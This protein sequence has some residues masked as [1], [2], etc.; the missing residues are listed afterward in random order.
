MSRPTAP[1]AGGRAA[2][3]DHA[4]PAVPSVIVLAGGR[5]A[6]LGG[7]KAERTVD[8][9]RLLDRVLAAAHELSDDVLLMSGA[10][11]LG[12]VGVRVLPDWPDVGGPLGGL[13]AGLTAARH[14][15]CLLLP[16]DLPQPSV[17]VARALLAARESGSR[18]VVVRDASGWQPFHGLYA[19][20]LLPELRAAVQRG[21]RSLVRWIA[22]LV[23]VR[24][25][26]ASALRDLDRDLDFLVDIDT[27]DDLVRA[28]RRLSAA[29]AGHA[30]RTAPTQGH[31]R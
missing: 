25:V 17:D 8:G 4:G 31:P 13:G 7:D 6:R 19:R 20:T 26:D 18:A 5:A 3:R 12:A 24:A 15:W 10:R 1:R 9:V 21:E 28:E 2:E 29:R 23:G 16:C 30:T 14:A 22:T 11:D 27:P